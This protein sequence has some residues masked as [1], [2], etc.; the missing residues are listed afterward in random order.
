MAKTMSINT[1]RVL[2]RVDLPGVPKGAIVGVDSN[3]EYNDG[4][5]T[6]RMPGGPEESR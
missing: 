2:S 6:K 3:L 1:P 5:S 4:P